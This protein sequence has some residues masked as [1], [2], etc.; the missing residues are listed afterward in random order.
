MTSLV[1]GRLSSCLFYE[2]S[3]GAVSLFPDTSAILRCTPHI[4]GS[5]DHC[6]VSV[7]ERRV[8]STDFIISIHNI[9]CGAWNKRQFRWNSFYLWGEEWLLF[10]VAFPFGLFYQNCFIFQNYVMTQ[11]NHHNSNKTFF[12][13]VFVLMCRCWE[14][15]INMGYWWIIRSPILFAYLVRLSVSCPDILCL[16]FY[17]WKKKKV[18]MHTHFSVSVSLFLSLCLSLSLVTL[19]LA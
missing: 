18:D 7:W 12:K 17:I 13:N 4:R 2:V 14:R 8:S 10:S 19:A 16:A 9:S 5:M 3:S 1:N 11:N 6:E 15:N